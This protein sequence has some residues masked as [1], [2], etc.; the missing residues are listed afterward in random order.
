MAIALALLSAIA[1]GAADFLGGVFGRRTAA[2]QVA[3]VGLTSAFVCVLPV[4][5]LVGGDPSTDDLAWA[6]VGGLFGGA[7][8]GF[9]YRGLAR[10]RMNVVAPVSG[11]GTALIP[12]VVGLALGERPGSLALLGMVLALPAIWLVAQIPDP[13]PDHVGGLMDGA[14]AGVGFGAIFVCLGQIHDDA[15]LAPLALLQLTSV[16]GVV[17]VAL[18]LSESWLPRRPAL[19]AI[20]LGPLLVAA[21]GLFQ[22]AAQHGLLTIV[23]VIGALYPAATVLL[24][25]ALLRERIHGVQGLGLALAA[26]AVALVAGG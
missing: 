21:T 15:G 23:S 3:V 4:A 16:V 12:V 6:A 7:G 8:T 9:L 5:I 17:L 22:W 2:W 18:A 10:G 14:L 11:I 25:A 13:D 26:V 24:A 20:A 19:P 1:Y